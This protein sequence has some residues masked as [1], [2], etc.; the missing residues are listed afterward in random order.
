MF[1]HISTFFCLLYLKLSV[2]HSHLQ[3]QRQ[4]QALTSTK[5]SV[6]AHGHKQAPTAT[7]VHFLEAEKTTSANKDT[8]YTKVARVGFPTLT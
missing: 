2:Q 7:S 6:T 1:L 4:L 3:I 5:N 8:S